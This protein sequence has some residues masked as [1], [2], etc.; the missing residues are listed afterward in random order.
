MAGLHPCLPHL[1]SYNSFLWHLNPI[2]LP[3]ESITTSTWF[4]LSKKW[5]SLWPHP[6]IKQHSPSNLLCLMKSKRQSRQKM[7]GQVSNASS[8]ILDST[9]LSPSKL[10]S[11]YKW[12]GFQTVASLV[13]HWKYRCACMS[14]AIQLS[15]THLLFLV[16]HKPPGYLILQKSYSFSTHIFL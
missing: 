2:S 1:F 6:Q 15:Q 8:S 3:S 9:F 13:R 16:L 5:S 14:M 10:L 11:D 7:M 4:V 12:E